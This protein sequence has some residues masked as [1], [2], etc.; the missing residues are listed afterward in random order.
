[1][2]KLSVTVATLMLTTSLGTA[3][4]TPSAT[5][6]GHQMAFASWSTREGGQRV[7]Y[8]AMGMNQ[9]PSDWPSLGFVGR[10]ECRK[11]TRRGHTHTVCAGGARGHQLAPGEFTMDPLLE[12]ATMA[13]EA[14]GK[15][16][17]VDWTGKGDAPEPFWHQHAGTGVG[18]FFMAH[19]QRR[20]QAAGKIFGTRLAKGF[21]FMVMGA[22]TEVWLDYLEDAT[23]GRVTLRDGILHFRTTL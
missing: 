8:F 6:D 15:A 18:I 2:R 10:A 1:M 23:G 4:A 19:M 9:A 20:A 7:I 21:G 3:F 17:S 16:N 11:V 12:T 22:Q 13:V 14:K 5:A